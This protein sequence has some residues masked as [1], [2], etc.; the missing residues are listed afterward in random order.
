MATFKHLDDLFYQ[1]TE[2]IGVCTRL[3]IAIIKTLAWI[4]LFPV[5]V[6]VTVVMVLEK[7]YFKFRER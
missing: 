5:I 7:I 1:L 6:M 2:D 3:G 4:I